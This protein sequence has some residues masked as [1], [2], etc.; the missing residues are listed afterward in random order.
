MPLLDVFCPLCSWRKSH[1]ACDQQ[2]YYTFWVHSPQPHKHPVQPATH[3][4]ITL[5][6]PLLSRSSDPFGRHVAIPCTTAPLLS[7]HNAPFAA[8]DL[9]KE[10]S[11]IKVDI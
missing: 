10:I 9:C 8:L 7:P 4:L 5:C 2:P 3:E 1:D 11:K 6:I